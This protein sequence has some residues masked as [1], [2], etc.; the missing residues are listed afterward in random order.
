[1]LITKRKLCHYFDSHPI[2]VVSSSALGD[3]I[4]SRESSGRI[5]KWGLELMG[6]NIS[7]IPCIAIKSQV[8]N[9]FMAEWMEEQAPPIPIKQ[10][11]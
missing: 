4:N 5:A 10:E 2:T 8:L 11:Y 3:I 1:V 6:H 7:Y 9:N